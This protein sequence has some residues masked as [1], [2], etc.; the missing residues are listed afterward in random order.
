M[1]LAMLFPRSVARIHELLLS[2]VGLEV[3]GELL[4]LVEQPRNPDVNPQ[5]VAV[6]LQR[7]VQRV[8]DHVQGSSDWRDK[9]N[10]ELLCVTHTGMLSTAD[11]PGIAHVPVP[12]SAIERIGSTTALEPDAHPLTA[13]LRLF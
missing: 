11:R 4:G 13:S 5:A 10:D 8:L 7:G 1:I 3:V 9:R 2:L 6:G 12:T